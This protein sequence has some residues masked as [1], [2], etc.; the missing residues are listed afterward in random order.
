MFKNMFSELASDTAQV[1]S[2]MMNIGTVVGRV[3][4]II[5]IAVLIL[6]VALFAVTK[7]KRREPCGYFPD[8]I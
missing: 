3:C 6:I 1:S 2:R 4:S 7:P 5:I 8:K